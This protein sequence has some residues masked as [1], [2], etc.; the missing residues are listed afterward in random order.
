MDWWNALKESPTGQRDAAF[1]A[2][3]IK[4]RTGERVDLKL[5][6]GQTGTSS[7]NRP[8]WVLYDITSP[9]TRDEYT[10]VPSRTGGE[11]GHLASIRAVLRAFAGGTPYGRGT[12]G[13]AWP[14]KIGSVHTA[15]LPVLLA[16]EPNAEQRRK[17][18]HK[19]Y[20][21]IATLIVPVAKIAKLGRLAALLETISAVGGGV[22]AIDALRKR[23]RTGQLYDLGTLLEIVQVVG[24]ARAGGAATAGTLRSLKV[25]KEVKPVAEGISLVAKLDTGVQLMVVTHS[26]VN[27]LQEA[28]EGSERRQILQGTYCIAKGIHDGTVTLHA[29]TAPK[30]A[31]DEPGQGRPGKAPARAAPAPG[32]VTSPLGTAKTKNAKQQV[33][34]H[35]GAIEVCPVQRCPRL[36]ETVGKRINDPGVSDKVRAAERAATNGRPA[37]AA[38]D[39]AAALDRAAQP[40][41][42]RVAAANARPVGKRQ[43]ALLDR[44]TAARA[45]RSGPPDSIAAGLHDDLNARIRDR[46]TKLTPDQVDAELLRI[47]VL[48]EV[49]A[50][51]R[52]WERDPGKAEAVAVLDTLADGVQYGRAKRA[53][54]YAYLDRARREIGGPATGA[55]TGTVRDRLAARHPD[56]AA[57]FATADAAFAKKE[58]KGPPPSAQFDAAMAVLEKNGLGEAGRAAIEAEFRPGGPADKVSAG[59]FGRATE[60]LK[61]LAV[62]V[63]ER[64]DLTTDLGHAR[65]MASIQDLGH[66]VAAAYRKGVTLDGRPIANRNAP[67][68]AE[69]M[70]RM[71]DAFAEHRATTDPIERLFG[72]LR[73]RDE[74]ARAGEILR[75]YDPRFSVSQSAGKSRPSSQLKGAREI[76][77]TVATK[78]IVGEPIARS[79]PGMGLEKYVLLPDEIG[80]LKTTPRSLAATLAAQVRGYHRAHLVGPGFGGELRE[81]LMLAPRDVNLHVQNEGVEAFIRASAASGRETTV[82]AKA[83]GRRIELPLAGGGVEH[84]DILT[85]V[86]YTITANGKTFA[87]VIT[88]GPPPGGRVA[89]T[90]T[91]PE[92]A[93]GADKLRGGASHGRRR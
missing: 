19:A 65:H 2:S 89:V 29:V 92:G 10:A 18:R 20:I 87:V 34:V 62:R 83:T 43:Q 4:E 27:C 73:L 33:E 85:K 44:V 93:P 91:I 7:E 82:E 6:L 23:A 50:Q 53:D 31:P 5:M 24:A 77:I 81:G 14:S 26:V 45:A 37:D 70:R 88:V 80:A 49:L 46:R 76:P 47:P 32:D 17:S 48:T 64:P 3:F 15:T 16:S 22:M 72:A 58:G 55:P 13:L 63:T 25:I 30:V 68:L 59:R 75:S 35:A 38:R 60:L 71:D 8:N 36:R 42:R 57:R 40:A 52:A 11:Q 41:S 54:V 21:D 39:G 28:K 66:Q 69:A 90:S 1:G 86:E 61:A 79:L 74:V 84:V 78:G 12:F 9:D 51:R 56:I 67:E